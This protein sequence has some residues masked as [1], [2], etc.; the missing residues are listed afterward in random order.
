[1][2]SSLF[3]REKWTE[4]QAND[5][6]AN[7]PF[8]AGCNFIPSD[9]INQIEM[10]SP[11]SFNAELI[12][13]ELGYAKKIGFNIMRV[14]LHELVWENAPEAFF[15]NIDK[16]LEI[17]DKHGIKTMFV[18]FDSCWNEVATY[19]KQPE[20]KGSHN[21]GWVKSPTEAT[22]LD[23]SKLPMLEKYVKEV[24]SRYANDKRVVVWDVYNEPG[25][26][27]VICV[28]GKMTG[29]LPPFLKRVRLL[30]NVFKWAREVNPSQP[31]TS[32]VF[33]GG[34]NPIAREI[35]PIQINESDII[36]FHS[37]EKPERLEKTI[38]YRKMHNR[39][40][41]CTEYMARNIGSTFAPSLEI[42][43][44]NK[45]AA[46]NWGLV[47][48]KTETHLP[49]DIIVKKHGKSDVWFHDILR[50]DGSAYDE[51]EVEYIKKIM[52]VK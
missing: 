2:L 31:L 19:G 20:P 47:V 33:T 17:A 1:M 45:V 5:W 23:D 37:Y 40:V 51:K 36:S 38:R 52:G 10:W 48:G 8:F 41:F 50:K 3:A 49:W 11:D 18:I 42:M 22:L 27:G 32:G 15:K 4:K 13:K 24:V 28:D 46:I 35:V 43:K 7:M 44:K 6:Y 30:K 12:D 21:S 9:A 16:Y 29:N 26:K 39:P 14:F 34:D 25:S